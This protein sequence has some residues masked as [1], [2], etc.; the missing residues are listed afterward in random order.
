MHAIESLGRDKFVYRNVF[1]TAVEQNKNEYIHFLPKNLL[2]FLFLTG[3]LGE[4]ACFW[5][6]LRGPRGMGG[7]EDA[8][9]ALVNT[10][11]GEVW[12]KQ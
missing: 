8:Q 4:W 7:G 9:C 2:S 11:M 12:G 1:F 5:M 10:E 6:L 3:N